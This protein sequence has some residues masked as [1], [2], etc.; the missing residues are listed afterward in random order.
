M[1]ICKLFHLNLETN[2]IANLYNRGQRSGT[3][4]S[5]FNQGGFVVDA[6]KKDRLIPRVMF[7]SKSKDW[8]I[9]LLNDIK[10]KGTSGKRENK[11]LVK[12]CLLII[13]N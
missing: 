1:A 10:L 5:I 4:I 3:G 13:K 6:C 12:A 7:K 11:F 2:D 9:I 8:R